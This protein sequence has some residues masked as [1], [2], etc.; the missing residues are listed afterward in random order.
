MSK[1]PMEVLKANDEEL[2]NGLMGLKG[3][4]TADGAIPLKYKIL[5]GL[6]V[7]ASIGTADGVRSFA[8]Q[9][10]AEGVSKEEI[11]EAV[12][13]VGYIRGISATLTAMEGL[14]DVL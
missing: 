13:V 4:M 6:C 7:D 3:L 9:A 12:R 1:N 11:V 5:M 10:L 8:K 14:S 2:L